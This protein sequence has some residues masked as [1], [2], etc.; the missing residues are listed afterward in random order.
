MKNKIKTVHFVG[1]GGSGMSGIAEVL[2]NQGFKIQGSDANPSFITERL[3]SQ[4][5]HVFKKHKGEN[6]IGAD[7][8]VISS[9]INKSNPELREARERGIPIVPRAS[10]LGELMRFKQGIAVAG[11]HGKTT[12]TSMISNVLAHA[13]FDPTYVLGGRIQGA[14][15]GAKLGNGDYL[16][17]EAD[18]SDRSFL[19]L[20]P[21]IGI[22]T[23][24]DN[25]HLNS[26]DNSLHKLKEAFISFVQKLPF[27]GPIFISAEDKLSQE[28]LP[29]LERR[30]TT[31]GFTGRS[32]ITVSNVITK[33]MRSKY[34]VS[35]SGFQNI[36][37]DLPLPG[38]HNVLNSL[39]AIGVARELGVNDAAIA[40]G[41]SEYEGVER[42]FQFHGSFLST[43][44]NI[45]T[46]IDDY[47]HHPTE[48]KATICACRE[49]F[50]EQEIRLI[51]QP[52]RYTRTR[53]LFDDF[54]SVLSEVDSLILLDVYE[55]G[56]IQIIGADSTTLARSIRLLGKVNP[57]VLSLNDKPLDAI[58]SV[59]ENNEVLLIMGAGSINQLTGLILDFFE[60]TVVREIL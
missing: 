35:Q 15:T 7:V 38:K 57:L 27:Y 60:S 25:D 51:F 12:T 37:I 53:D 1:I 21:V 49:A 59:I 54:V 28:L 47:G 46:L 45:F 22:I 3:A 40:K 55:A 39:F 9:A 56:E 42:R 18:E 23:N 17:V 52:H 5:V 4:G 26:Y 6:V 29:R 10:M 16:V 41:L 20:T 13:G 32:D 14:E 50:P 36:K 11:T 48:I 8:C 30:V 58:D 43:S 44:G 34:L 19:N 33:E 2:L 31:V 24:I